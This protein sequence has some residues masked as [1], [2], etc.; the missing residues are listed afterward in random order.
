MPTI[1]VEQNLRFTFDDAWS[2]I[3]LDEHPFFRERLMPLQF[4]DAVYFL[5]LHPGKRPCIS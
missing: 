4:D 2:V 5:G 3:K 1:I